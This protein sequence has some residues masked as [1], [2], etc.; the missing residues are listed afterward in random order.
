MRPLC[1]YFV[2]S[3][4]CWRPALQQQVSIKFLHKIRETWQ[5]G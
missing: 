2:I 4:D 3:V 1:D 5:A